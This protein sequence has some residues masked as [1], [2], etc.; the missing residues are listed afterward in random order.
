[1]SALPALLD[2]LPSVHPIR[3]YLDGWETLTLRSLIVPTLI[4]WLALEVAFFLLIIYLHRQLDKCTPPP[5]A[6]T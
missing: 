4:F 5:S 1:M 3:D 6:A 2:F